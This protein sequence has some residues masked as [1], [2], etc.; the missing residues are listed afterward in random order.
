MKQLSQLIQREFSLFWQNKVFVVAF[1]VMPLVLATVLGFVYYDGKVTRLPVLVVDEDHSPTSATFMDMLAENNTLHVTTVR[2]AT[3]DLGQLMLEKR[4]AAIVVIPFRFEA[5]IL[6]KRVPEVNCYLNMGNTL[7]AGAAGNAIQSSTA[8]LNVGILL[9]TLGKKGIPLSL[10]PQ[11]YEAFHHNVFQQYN[12]AG[13]YLYFLWPGLI[14]SILHQLL[15]LATAAGFAQEFANK[16]FNS[17]GL[18]RYS[19]SAIELIFVKIFP[20]LAM[21]LLTVCAYF[22]LSL[23][24]RIP[25]PAHPEVLFIAA[26]LLAIGTCMLGTFFS[27]ASPLPLK[28][29]QTVMT[30]GSPAFS[31]S[32][33][34]WSSEQIPFVLRALSEI[35]PLTPFLRAL[36]LSWIQ[37]A[38]LEEVMPQLYHQLILAAFYFLL[39]LLLLRKKINKAI[40]PVSPIPATL[41]TI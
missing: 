14:F 38:S 20:F 33:F 8:T 16:T 9:K 23:L 6:T 34:S 17:T 41:Q 19:H 4:V 3:T 22:L 35:V 29:S 28:A 5:D 10:A 18:L 27:I 25:P 21:S 1:L 39:G 7:S 2:R 12:P 37:G 13:N 11:Q 36:R 31:L 24:F 26:L 40:P 15:L 30:I 32:G